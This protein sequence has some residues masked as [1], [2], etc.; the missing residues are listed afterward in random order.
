MISAGNAGS[1]YR[2][3]MLIRAAIVMPNRVPSA[4]AISGH[5]SRRG[6]RNAKLANPIAS[7]TS[8]PIVKET[9]YARI[10]DELLVMRVE[11]GVPAPDIGSSVR[12]AARPDKLHWFDA[13]SGKRLAG[14]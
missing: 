3:P 8:P 10:G 14:A 7:N 11:E 12:V 4:S 2:I 5:S 9:I 13:G 6:R 1:R